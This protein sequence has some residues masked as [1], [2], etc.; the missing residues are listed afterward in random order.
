MKRNLGSGLARLRPMKQLVKR[1]VRSLLRRAAE[2]SKRRF[3]QRYGDETSGYWY[4]DEHGLPSDD[5]VWY[6]PSD[7][8]ALTKAFRRLRPSRDD[9]LIDIGSG[10]GRA[11]LVA[12]QFPFGRVIGLELSA[13]M[14]AVAEAAVAKNRTQLQPGGYDFVTADV[15]EYELPD[16]VTVV[17]MYCPFIGDI[18][19]HFLGRLL[20]FADCSDRPI[21]L[22]YNY[23]FHHAQ[24]VETGRVD[25]L[26]VVSA[27][28]P[29]KSLAL[30]E[31]IVTY[32]I[33]PSDNR[34]P[35]PSPFRSQLSRRAR[36]WLGPYDPGG[37]APDV[38]I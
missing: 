14:N 37:S 18:F 7:W 23:P 29:P 11:L 2:W 32:R 12:G 33:R 13:E 1:V 5:R 17:Y 35:G 22:V 21:R 28:W 8:Y 38:D 25:V 31:V 36:C 3:V 26:D 24:L 34:A 16:D 30:P 15:L 19:T 9:V 27:F 20:A 6:D 4:L 10:K